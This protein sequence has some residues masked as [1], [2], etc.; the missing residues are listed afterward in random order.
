MTYIQ[1]FVLV[2]AGISITSAWIAARAIMDVAPAH[3]KLPLYCMVASC[4][5]ASVA[6][7]YIAFG[8]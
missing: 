1:G 4:A 7:L 5:V 3:V 2:T 8:K 6:A